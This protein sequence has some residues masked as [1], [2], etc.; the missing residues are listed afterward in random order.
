MGCKRLV[1]GR[2]VETSSNP[3]PFINSHRIVASPLTDQ[4][5]ASQ[6]HLFRGI[7]ISES[8]LFGFHVYLRGSSA[9]VRAFRGFFAS[10]PTAR[11]TLVSGQ[12]DLQKCWELCSPAFKGP[13]VAHK[14]THLDPMLPPTLG[15]RAPQRPI[16]RT[17]PF[18]ALGCTEVGRAC[19]LGVERPAPSTAGR[20]TSWKPTASLPSLLLCLLLFRQ[21]RCCEVLLS[22]FVAGACPWG[23]LAIPH[24]YSRFWSAAI[25]NG[26][27][28]F[29]KKKKKHRQHTA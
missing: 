4:L 13:N 17:I 22:W 19:G 7:P 21:C 20:F 29:V 12:E 5:G 15:L 25:P 9:P 10:P 27:S 24:S 14:R 1:G 18:I 6:K 26:E 3:H 28:C 11:I 23:K 8:P 2:Q 16:Q